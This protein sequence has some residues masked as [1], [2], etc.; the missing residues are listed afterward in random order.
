[1]LGVRHRVRLNVVI[2]L[3]WIQRVHIRALILIISL[4][5]LRILW[6]DA[7]HLGYEV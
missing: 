4:L 3:I 6:Q 5:V 1:M 7:G 2:C